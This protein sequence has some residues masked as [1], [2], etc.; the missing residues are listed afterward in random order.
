[1]TQETTQW[2]ASWFDSPYY[3]ILYKDR[4]YDEA[5]LFMDNLTQ[6]LNL[7]E[8][9]T[10]MD[11][12]CGKGRHSVYLNTLGYNVTWLDLSENSINYA[13]Q[14]ENDSLNFN[15]HDMSLPYTSQFDAVLNLFTSFGY[16]E[17][18]SDN[19]E[20]IK[21]IKS[22]LSQIRGIIFGLTIHPSLSQNLT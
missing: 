17:Q 10:I 22:N 13:K 16:F 15:V 18:E 20:T 1:M 4:G 19:L 21:A 2:F 6:Y 11:L 14:F 3:H 5:Q 12:A 7:P 9:A 8:Q